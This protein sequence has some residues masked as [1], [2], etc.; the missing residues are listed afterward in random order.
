MLNADI[1]ADDNSS[2]HPLPVVGMEVLPQ[3]V[4]WKWYQPLVVFTLPHLLRHFQS[5]AWVI[6][7]IISLFPA[8]QALGKTNGCHPNKQWSTIP[9]MGMTL[10]AR[11]PHG[12][13]DTGG[14]ERKPARVAQMETTSKVVKTRVL[15]H[16]CVSLLRFSFESRPLVFG[17][18]LVFVLAVLLRLGGDANSVIG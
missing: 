1:E 8:M 14:I 16:E 11:N 10:R 13:A 6:L 4:L 15:I 2:S 12:E 9:P 5:L 18:C 7:L 3:K 17:A